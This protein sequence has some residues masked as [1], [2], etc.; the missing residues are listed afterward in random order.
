MS[1]VHHWKCQDNAADTVVAAAV[2]TAAALVGGDNTSAL[3]A[4]DGPGTAYPR[5]L[6]LDGAADGLDISAAAVSFASGTAFT[7]AAW[8]KGVT[9]GAPNRPVWGNN[10][11][12]L[13]RIS[14]VATA[15]RV[16]CLFTSGM[17]SFT[18]GAMSTGVWYHLLVTRTAGNSVRVFW[19]G[20]ESSSGA[21]AIAQTFAPTRAGF[22]Q[23]F[24]HGYVCDLRVY[25]SDESA[26]VAAIMAEKNLPAAGGT[27]AMMG[28]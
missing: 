8:V 23:N 17:T 1:L 3:S 21:Q 12:N 2:G 7:F 11:S 19:D 28:V 25:N 9:F 10:G 18:T 22:A 5:S 6:L 26:N 14:L 24:F 20:V 13:P 15:P 16:D 4:V 27:A